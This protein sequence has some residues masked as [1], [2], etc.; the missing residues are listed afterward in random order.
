MCSPLRTV[1]VTRL[2]YVRSR[3]EEAGENFS[4]FAYSQGESEAEDKFTGKE[5]EISEEIQCQGLV[6]CLLQTVN[7]TQFP[8]VLLLFF[9]CM[10]A[11]WWLSC[12]ASTTAQRSTLRRARFQVHV[13]S[14]SE[15]Q[16]NIL[17]YAT[18]ST[19]E[20]AVR[21]QQSSKTCRDECTF[22][23]ISENSPLI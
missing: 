9:V 15:F 16:S 21:Q 13:M 17:C 14:S 8:T 3:S 19:A 4:F 11:Y 7:V 12:F 23:T 6:C 2:L 22:K 10:L 5:R 18:A 1:W 20:R